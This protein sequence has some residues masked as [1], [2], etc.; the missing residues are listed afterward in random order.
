MLADIKN[1]CIFVRQTRKNRNYEN[2]SKQQSK[3]RS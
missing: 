3:K 1:L 2:C